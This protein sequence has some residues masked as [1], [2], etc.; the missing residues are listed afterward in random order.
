MSARGRL[1]LALAAPAAAAGAAAVI[2]S[3]DVRQASAA[4]VVLPLAI[5]LSFIA[6][7]LIAWR[8]RPRNPLGP[9]MVAT[10][11]AKLA[12]SLWWSQDPEVF[13]AGHVLVPAYLG[14]LIYIVL[15]FPDGRLHSRFE[16]VLFGVTLVGIVPIQLLWLLLGGEHHVGQCE[17]CPEDVLAITHADD[18]SLAVHV[19][20]QL[21]GA[22]VG[23]LAAAVLLRR[24]WRASPPLRFAIAPVLWV[25]AV[26]CIAAA[27]WVGNS[28]VGDP[29][30]VA[31]RTVVDLAL[32]AMAVAFLA[33]LLRTRLARSAV[34]DLVVEL[35]RT[36]PPGGVR[37]ALA[38]ALHDP[39]LALAYW[40][41]EAGRYVDATGKPV[42]LPAD[43]DHAVT[44]VERDS[45]RVAALVHD[46]ALREDAELLDSACAAAALAL[47]NERLQADLRARLEE[48]QASRARLVEATDSERRR[49]ERDLHDGTQQQLV[50]IAMSLGLVD[51]K[52]AQEPERAQALLREART[53]LGT[54]LEE[55]RQ[56]TH[57]I[58]PGALAERGLE[59]A[60]HELAYHARVPFELDVALSRRLPEEVETA[61]YYVV[62]E[63]LTNI[64]KHAE[65]TG[66]GVRVSSHNG[67]AKI[68]VHDDGR[69][70]ATLEGGS[71]L[72]GLRDRVEALGGRLEVSSPPGGGTTL[73]AQIP[74]A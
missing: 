67:L 51:A 34:A 9:V 44:L 25:G 26:T 8:R 16:R 64:A 19:T 36:Q 13:A 33:G 54:A 40:L 3:N 30:G 37:D 20:Q 46:P 56:I 52:L 41:P 14:G 2:L 7:G 32:A 72:R 22:V 29:L 17:G 10:G 1:A 61:A 62:S 58:H 60:L 43:D 5:G 23:A 71:G 31:P 15:A 18:L 59:S 53:D 28:A 50:S 11:Y 69:G 38:R 66:A 70:G 24:W 49:I 42:Q 47:E 57:G 63:A 65:A 12:G 48:L 35:S 6:S 45:R 55:L 68:E 73:T 39:S 27:V 21:A 74:C 4:D